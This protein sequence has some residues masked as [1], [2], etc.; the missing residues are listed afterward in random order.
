MLIHET[1]KDSLGQLH[2][3]LLTYLLTLLVTANWEDV[4]VFQFLLAGTVS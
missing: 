4:S 2:L 3:D 1:V